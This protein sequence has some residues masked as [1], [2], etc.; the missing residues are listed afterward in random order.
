MHETEFD[1][2]FKTDIAAQRPIVEFLRGDIDVLHGMPWAFTIIFLF[3]PFALVFSNRELIVCMFMSIYRICSE[4][5]QFFKISAFNSRLQW[6]L[7][8]VPWLQSRHLT[9]HASLSTSSTSLNRM[10]INVCVESWSAATIGRHVEQGAGVTSTYFLMQVRHS[11]KT[12][13][14]LIPGTY[15]NTQIQGVISRSFRTFEA[16]TTMGKGRSRLAA[17]ALE[18]VI[19]KAIVIRNSEEGQTPV[20]MLGKLA[21]P[22]WFHPAIVADRKLA[23]IALDSNIYHLHADSTVFFFRRVIAPTRLVN[24]FFEEFSVGA[25]MGAQARVADCQVTLHAIEVILVVRDAYVLLA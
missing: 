11:C 17:Q 20:L 21:L 3:P 5:F 9:T 12:S 16:T 8:S 25:R 7:R 4:V 10:E 23:V 2:T 14:S 1:R 6:I 22:G 18:L 19:I 15:V 13:P 24:G